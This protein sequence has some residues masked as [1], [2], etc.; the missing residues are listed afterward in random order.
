M[1]RTIKWAGANDTAGETDIISRSPAPSGT[2]INVNA[3]MRHVRTFITFLAVLAAALRAGRILAV[4]A[5]DH[6]EIEKNGRRLKYA[7]G[8]I[9]AKGRVQVWALA[10]AGASME[11]EIRR[12]W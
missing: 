11:C 2:A 7:E 4:Q 10:L 1:A 8:S 5:A 6:F 9:G 3:P 12:F